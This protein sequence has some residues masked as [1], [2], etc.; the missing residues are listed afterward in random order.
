MTNQVGPFELGVV[1]DTA[2]GEGEPGPLLPTGWE[3]WSAPAFI[4]RL[5]RLIENNHTAAALEALPSVP[6]ASPDEPFSVPVPEA[7]VFTDLDM[8]TPAPAMEEQ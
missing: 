8:G 7:A 5:S 3:Q 1:R 2:E 6:S 4:A